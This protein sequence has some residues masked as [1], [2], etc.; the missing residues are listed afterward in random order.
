[1]IDHLVYVVAVNGSDLPFAAYADTACAKSVVGQQE[2]D[3][4]IKFCMK[5]NGLTSLWMIENLFDLVP[6]SEFGPRKL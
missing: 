6:A 3:P 2:C 4:L 5:S 1:M